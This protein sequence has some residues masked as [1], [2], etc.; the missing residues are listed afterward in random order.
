MKMKVVPYTM[1]AL[2]P[3]NETLTPLDQ[4]LPGPSRRL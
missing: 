1:G 3:T 2:A 4:A